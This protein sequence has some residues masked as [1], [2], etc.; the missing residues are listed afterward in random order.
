MLP[1]PPVHVPIVASI[2]GTGIVIGML[3]CYIRLESTTILWLWMGACVVWMVA[4]LLADGKYPGLDVLIGGPLSGLAYVATQS[5]LFDRF[6]FKNRSRLRDLDR[7]ESGDYTSD[8]LPSALLWG[9]V[10]GVV[11]G[12]LTELIVWMLRRRKRTNADR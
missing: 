4:A 1:K 3:T 10:A 7:W 5:A 11:V 9:L 6:W 2:A 8:A 12:G